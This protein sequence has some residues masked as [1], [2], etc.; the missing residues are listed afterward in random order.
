LERG[1]GNQRENPGRNE[2]ALEEVKK[3]KKNRKILHDNKMF[4]IIFVEILQQSLD[5]IKRRKE[6]TAGKERTQKT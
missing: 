1:A 2:Y 4:C 6:V 3:I 5:Y